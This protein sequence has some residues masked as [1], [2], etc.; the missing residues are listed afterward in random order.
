MVS[1]DERN[2]EIYQKYLRGSRKADLAREYH[3]S[4]A[5]IRAIIKRQEYLTT[6]YPACELVKTDAG[7]KTISIICMVL[8]NKNIQS[9]EDLIKLDIHEAMQLVGNRSTDCM[10][11]IGILYMNAIQNK[12]I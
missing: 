6:T 8:K 7:D 9:K 2:Y 3:L 4:T 1:M 5:R 11:Y 12:D 10:K